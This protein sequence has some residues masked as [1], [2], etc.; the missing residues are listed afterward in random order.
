[1]LSSELRYEL[2]LVID[3]ERGPG[4]EYALALARRTGARLLLTGRTPA[5]TDRPTWLDAA[6]ET[7]DMVLAQLQHDLVVRQRMGPAG[8]QRQ[9]QRARAQ[10]ELMRNLDRLRKAGI[11]ARYQACER[12]DTLSLNRLAGEEPIRGVIVGP[13][14]MP[15]QLPEDPGA[16]LQ[17][18]SLG[19]LLTL[20]PLLNWS[21]LRVLAACTPLAGWAGQAGQGPL[22]LAGDMLGWLIQS[23]HQRHPQL[24]GLAFAMGGQGTGASRS[25]MFLEAL[26]GSELPRVAVCDMPTAR[27]SGRPMASFPITPRP[28]GRLVQT[29]EDRVPSVRFER[30][31]DL[32]LDQHRLDDEPALPA[33]FVTEIFA[34]L[35]RARGLAVRDLRF[36]RP[37]PVR[38]ASLEAE[39][40][41]YDGRLM[42]VPTD[43]SELPA[44][45]LP[46]LAFATCRLGPPVR[47]EPLGMGFSPRE[48][49]TLHDAAQEAVLPCYTL[50]EERFA[51][52]LGLGPIFRG[53]RS[54][55]HTGDRYLGLI[56]LTDEAMAALA[57]PGAFA[58]QPVLADL[59]MQVA[60]AWALEEHQ[61]LALP[62]ALAGLHILGTSREREAVI[63]CK[64]RDLSASH[65][66]VDLVVRE[67]DHRPV[68]ILEQ[69]ELR[70]VADLEEADP[71]DAP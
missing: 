58:F 71:T 30:A 16:F 51:P 1:M 23:L 8:A 9:V 14:P 7:L 18:T 20:L 65:I 44:K 27:G 40:L 63:V 19:T 47:D 26:L 43:R 10:W 31:R 46:R 35:A 28:R 22:A 68:L 36:R 15:R 37:A 66:A 17:L 12:P 25:D 62:T 41:D 54:T 48:L 4:F 21:Q 33:A 60:M 11:S 38:G 52:T 57:V 64:A 13:P 61:R 69:L 34:E 3:G 45:I 6:P 24:R 5:P 55:R 32:W 29:P 67:P 2:L 53:I 70:A 50:L 56:S 49:L 42:L 39:V 59:A